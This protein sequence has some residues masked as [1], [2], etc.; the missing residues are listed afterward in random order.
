MS[1]RA[2]CETP[3]VIDKAEALERATQAISSDFVVL[4]EHT[5]EESFGWVFFFESAR[6]LKTGKVSDRLAGNSPLVVFRDSGEVRPTGTAYP[7]EHYLAP[8][9]EERTERQR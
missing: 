6:Y 4:E 2:T 5:L 7:V 8:I 9:R 3:G 1:P